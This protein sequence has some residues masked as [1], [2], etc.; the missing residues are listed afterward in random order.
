MEEQ[1]VCKESVYEKLFLSLAPLLRN[2]LLFKFK[3]LERAED[4]VQEAFFIMWKNCKKVTPSLAKAYLFRVAQNQFLKL[5][6]KDK[7]RQ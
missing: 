6:D 1:D 5:L 2:F 7:V 3:N 4:M